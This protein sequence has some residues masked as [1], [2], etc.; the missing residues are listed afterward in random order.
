L[1]DVDYDLHVNIFGRSFITE[2]DKEARWEG[3]IQQIELI[4]SYDKWDGIYYFPQNR[5]DPSVDKT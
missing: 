3:D 4:K 2:S 1:P 5:T